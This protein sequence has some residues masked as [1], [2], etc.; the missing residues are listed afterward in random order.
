MR[1][2]S[3]ALFLIFLP[4][5]APAAERPPNVLFLLADDLGHGDVGFN[6]RTDWPTP[7]LD[8]LAR[9]GTVFT[10]WY[11]PGVVCAPSR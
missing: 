10:R 8:R 1:L 3:P 4:L 2:T 7:H 5:S 11:A 9:E 6:G